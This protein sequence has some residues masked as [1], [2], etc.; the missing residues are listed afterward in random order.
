MLILHN[1]RRDRSVYMS[2]HFA[3]KLHDQ[4][5]RSGRLWPTN[6]TIKRSMNIHCP[7][8]SSTIAQLRRIL[9]SN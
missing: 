2:S 9:E 5:I 1:N 7:V 8:R 6:G 3:A 4:L